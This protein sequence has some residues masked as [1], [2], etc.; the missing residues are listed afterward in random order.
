MTIT[1]ATDGVSLV[2]EARGVKPGM[3]G[4]GT[5]R[6]CYRYVVDPEGDPVTM[7]EL[8]ICPAG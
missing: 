3:F 1:R 4:N 8:D 7:T 6:R 2:L 5:V